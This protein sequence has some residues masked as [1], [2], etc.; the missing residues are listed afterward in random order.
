M[1][2]IYSKK[3]AFLFFFILN[4]GIT[5]PIF[6]VFCSNSL[7][8]CFLIYWASFAWVLFKNVDSLAIIHSFFF[9]LRPYWI[10]KLQFILE[11]FHFFCRKLIFRCK[12]IFL[13]SFLFFVKH[14]ILFVWKLFGKN[15]FFQIF[16]VF[17]A[18]F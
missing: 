13:K 5:L 17:F 14:K 16:H 12:M 7:N 2:R 4:G 3:I 10:L 6:H 8:V 18:Y 11:P 15:W 1:F 9:L